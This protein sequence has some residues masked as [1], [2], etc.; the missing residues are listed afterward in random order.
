MEELRRRIKYE[1]EDP[2]CEYGITVFIFWT[3]SGNE[4]W[5]ANK[6][7]L[8][9]ATDEELAALWARFVLEEGE[10]EVAK[11]GPDAYQKHVHGYDSECG[12]QECCEYRTSKAEYYADMREDR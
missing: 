4:T 12:C 7:E 3:W 6:E 5:G 8:L 2:S 11:S 1:E 10:E 9:R